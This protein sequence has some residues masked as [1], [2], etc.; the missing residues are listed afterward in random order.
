MIVQ[1]SPHHDPVVLSIFF[2]EL[3]YLQIFSIML[4]RLAVTQI[5]GDWATELPGGGPSSFY[6]ENEVNVK[7]FI[8]MVCLDKGDL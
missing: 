7:L 3:H 1:F 2:D 5:S 6:H 4:I 8:H